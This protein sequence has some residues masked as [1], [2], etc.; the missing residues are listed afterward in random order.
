MQG[1]LLACNKTVSWRKL[2]PPLT[3]KKTQVTVVGDDR[4]SSTV[5]PE[6]RLTQEDVREAVMKS[7]DI[8]QPPRRLF[9]AMIQS[10]ASAASPTAPKTM[11]NHQ[12]L[13]FSIGTR[14]FK[15][16]SGRLSFP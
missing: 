11:E 8:A 1:L 14:N 7:A 4:D 15:T 2:K 13:S 10:A 16:P 3:Q 6:E 9:Q 12:S 5:D